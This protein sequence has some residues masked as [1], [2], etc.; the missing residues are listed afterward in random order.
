L[1]AKN[2]GNSS[3]ARIIVTVLRN[4][5]PIDR[6]ASER[7]RFNREVDNPMNYLGQDDT[8]DRPDRISANSR[9]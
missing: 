5:S 1:A 6:V 9:P 7:L 8:S 2:Y 3:T 4:E